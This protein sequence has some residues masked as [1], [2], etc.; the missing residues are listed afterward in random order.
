MPA[1]WYMSVEAMDVAAPVNAHNAATCAGQAQ[2]ASGRRAGNQR[3][4]MP[5]G[6]QRQQ[7]QQQH[8]DNNKLD[9]KTFHDRFP[10]SMLHPI[11]SLIS[12]GLLRHA[13]H[14]PLP[15]LCKYGEGQSTQTP[16]KGLPHARQELRLH[17]KLQ[18][19]QRLNNPMSHIPI[20]KSSPVISTAIWPIDKR[21]Q[22]APPM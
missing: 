17:Q 3:M 16:H 8:G 21:E 9:N 10:F 5:Y 15:G 12:N 19:T 18:S 7:R 11:G 20:L 1:W 2:P 14:R 4:G 6:Y 13:S 22:A